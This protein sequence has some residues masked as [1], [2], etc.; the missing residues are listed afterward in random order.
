M[1]HSAQLINFCQH[2]ADR[3]HTKTHRVA[4]REQ[5]ADRITKLFGPSDHWRMTRLSMR[6]SLPLE[7][8]WR[9]VRQMYGGRSAAER[10]QMAEAEQ[11][12]RERETST[13]QAFI[14]TLA[15]MELTKRN[16]RTSE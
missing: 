3:Q 2:H 11:R 10:Q 15:M 9:K 12:E 1:R 5:P 7:D 13:M 16:K 14:L 4:G 8:M 6:W